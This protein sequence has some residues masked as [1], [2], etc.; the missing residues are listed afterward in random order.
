MTVSQVMFSLISFL[1]E[2]ET[3][4]DPIVSAAAAEELVSVVFQFWKS[5]HIRCDI[6]NISYSCSVASDMGK[7]AFQSSLFPVMRASFKLLFSFLRFPPLDC[8]TVVV[9]F[10]G[11]PKVVIRYTIS[12]HVA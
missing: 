1:R 5:S 2:P 12:R 10:Q 3:D 9:P 8:L 6:H 4:P 7:D 11:G